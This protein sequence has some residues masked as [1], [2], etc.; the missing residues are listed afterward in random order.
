MWRLTMNVEM[1][2][3]VVQCLQPDMREYADNEAMMRWIDYAV[4]L[5]EFLFIAAEEGCVELVEALNKVMRDELST[6]VKHEVAVDIASTL[7]NLHSEFRG[8]FVF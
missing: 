3:N 7:Q 4:W 6:S 1:V 2:N 8:K 5:D